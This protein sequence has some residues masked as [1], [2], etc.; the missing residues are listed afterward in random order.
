MQAIIIYC[1]NDDS[2]NECI[3]EG[4]IYNGISFDTA[5]AEMTAGN[6]AYYIPLTISGKT[7][8]EK[9]ENLRTLA[10]NWQ[11][12]NHDFC[13]WSYG[14]LATINDFFETNGRRYGLLSEF[15]ENCIC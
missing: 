10:K 14:E 1:W 13:G 5:A 15:K 8:T 9:K 12:S 3:Y 2:N 7:Y 4:G 6:I 11:W